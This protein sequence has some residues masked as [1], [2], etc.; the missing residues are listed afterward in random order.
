M[1]VGCLLQVPL[2]GSDLNLWYRLWPRICPERQALLMCR[3]QVLPAC[4][5]AL[6]SDRG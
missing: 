1:L 3:L 5:P 4:R 6:V 2:L